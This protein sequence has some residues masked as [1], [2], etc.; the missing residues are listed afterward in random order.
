MIFINR[1]K[2]INFAANR[3]LTG[4][5]SARGRADESRGIFGPSPTEGKKPGSS[6]G[7]DVNKARGV[8]G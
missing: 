6:D 2:K 1:L 8:G 3:G 5:S 7:N 4:G